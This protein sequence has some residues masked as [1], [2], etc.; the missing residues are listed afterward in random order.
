MKNKNYLIIILT[1]VCMTSAIFS[2]A[3]P[4]DIQREI[5]RSLA[6]ATLQSEEEPYTVSAWFEWER[7]VTL[8]D[9]MMRSPRR[10]A[11]KEQVIHTKHKYT[12]CRGVLVDDGTRV[13]LPAS[14]V[15]QG[16]YRLRQFSLHFSNNRTTFLGGENLQI[17]DEIAQVQVSHSVTE[18]VPS[19]SVGSV[20]GGR[21]LQE[22]Y[23][24]E[25]TTQLY[26]FFHAHNVGP[27]RRTRPGVTLGHGQ[28]QV[29]DALIYQGRVVALVKKAVSS[30]ADGF[31]GVSENAFAVIR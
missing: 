20:P 23:G 6:Q 11:R 22:S 17:G 5:I 12:Q 24:A 15:Q 31:G 8:G 9:M 26:S 21:G 29:G 7:E 10:P 13:L 3:E 14:C 19:L 30:Y 28:L 25:M 18:G 1:V 2:F 16:K 27:L 4:V